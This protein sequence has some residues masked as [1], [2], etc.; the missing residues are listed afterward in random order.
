MPVSKAWSAPLVRT[1]AL[2]FQGHRGFAIAWIAAALGHGALSPLLAYTAKRVVDAIVAGSIAGIVRWVLWE[3]AIAGACTALMRLAMDARM[4]LRNRVRLE[5]RLQITEKIAEL[6]LVQLEEPG[7]QDQIDTARNVADTRP[8]GLVN[9]ILTATRSALGLVIYAGLLFSFSPWAVL[10][11]LAVIPGAVAELWRA[12]IAARGHPDRIQDLRRLRTFQD[13]LFSDSAAAENRL[14]GVTPVLLDR[15]RA[16]GRRL[17]ADARAEWKRTLLVS[18]ACQLLPTLTVNVTYLLMAVATVRGQLTVG[19]LTLYGISLTGA[20]RFS[21]T[22]LLSGRSALE[23]WHHVRTLFALLALAPHIEPARFPRLGAGECARPREAAPAVLRLENVSFRYPGSDAWAIRNLDLEIAQ[24]DFVALVGGNGDGKTTLLKLMAG[25]LTPTEGSVTLDGRDLASWDPAERNRRFGV[26][27]QGS[28]RYGL[29][30][31]DNVELGRADTGAGHALASALRAS[32][33]D[34]VVAQLARGVDTELV[35]SLPDGTGLSGGQWQRIALARC[36][37]RDDADYLLLDEPTSAL[38]AVVE[39]RVIA[40]LRSL[41]PSKA[42]VL[43]THRSSLLRPTD[44]IVLLERGRLLRD[45]A[46]ALLRHP[47]WTATAAGEA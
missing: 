26:V 9:E 41:P 23:G 40:H 43:I 42:V 14:Y 6:P 11:L 21:Q 12:R 2:V 18:I 34:D 31:R 32:C 24:G 22:V 16:L 27:F 7:V 33:A 44:K 8:L 15:S 1:F 45:D 38:D 3:L 13:T 29:T 37:V 20:Q 47:R 36:F 39:Q 30:L 28:A 25:L 17:S 10:F 4:L 46:P 5:T 19:E 35:P